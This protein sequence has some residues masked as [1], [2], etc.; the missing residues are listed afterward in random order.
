[1]FLEIKKT[2]A[3]SKQAVAKSKIAV[4]EGSAQTA[5]IGFPQNIPLLIGYAVQA[6]AIFSSVKS[7]VKGISGVEGVGNIG[8]AG[9]AGGTDPV[10]KTSGGGSGTA[11][12]AATAATSPSFNVVQGSQQN[13]ILGDVSEGVNRPTRAYV[14]G[15]EAGR[16][17]CNNYPKFGLFSMEIRELVLSEEDLEAGV[18]AISIVSEGAIEEDFIALSKKDVN[19]KTIDKE[20]RILMGPALIPDKMIYRREEENEYYIY[21]SK[22]T[23][24][25]VSEAYLKRG[26]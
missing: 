12:Q 3:F 15:K 10:P 23:V 14:V 6:A 5:K 18:D 20:Q 21:F 19:L 9:A 24:K 4:A 11:T 2:I 25:K 26:Y 16:L 7:A 17:N 22:E 1:M 8:D 13:Q